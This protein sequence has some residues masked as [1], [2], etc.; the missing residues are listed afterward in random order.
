MIVYFSR[1]SR[2]KEWVP[3]RINMPA[4]PRIGDTVHLPEG[5]KESRP[6]RVHHV[7]WAEENGQWQAEI[8]VT[9]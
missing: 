6:W 2:G 8:G 1:Y 3:L 9:A 4:V 7:A 5:A